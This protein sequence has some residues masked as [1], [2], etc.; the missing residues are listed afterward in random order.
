MDPSKFIH[1]VKPPRFVSRFPEKDVCTQDLRIEIKMLVCWIR[2][3]VSKNR[4]SHSAPDSRK[5][6][7]S[8]GLI[9]GMVSES[10]GRG[11]C[12]CFSAR[13]NLEK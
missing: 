1:L 12:L 7:P 9:N 2:P 11:C 13:K 6:I 10:Q 5:R 3:V 4:R 8:T